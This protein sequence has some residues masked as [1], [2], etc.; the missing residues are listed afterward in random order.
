MPWSDLSAFVNGVAHDAGDLN[1]M[2][3]NEVWLKQI[4]DRV[5]LGSFACGPFVRGSS[6]TSPGS[7]VVLLFQN[8]Q[9]TASGLGDFRISWGISGLVPEGDHIANLQ[10]TFKIGLTASPLTTAF[11]NGVPLVIPNEIGVDRYTNITVLGNVH[12]AIWPEAVGTD[13]RGLSLALDVWAHNN[14]WS[15]DW[16]PTT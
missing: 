8:S 1:P 12:D 5:L 4:T 6:Y 2:L 16:S 10:V 9:Q 3:D 11:A 13:V 14:S 7:Q 15:S